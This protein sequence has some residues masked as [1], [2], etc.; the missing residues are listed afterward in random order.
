[1]EVR[2]NG[3]GITAEH[4]ADFQVIWDTRHTGTGAFTWEENCGSAVP[5][6]KGTTVHVSLPIKARENLGDQDTH[7]G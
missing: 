6:I 3:E 5:P 4:L 1:M 2:D 7:S